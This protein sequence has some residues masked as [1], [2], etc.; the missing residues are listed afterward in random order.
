MSTPNRLGF[1]GERGILST[2]DWVLLTDGAGE[3]EAKG[4][5]GLLGIPLTVAGL[6]EK[7]EDSPA[8]FDSR[9][10]S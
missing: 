2:A 5:L 6:P 1:Q 7:G 8:V 3:F 9:D 4:L 10:F